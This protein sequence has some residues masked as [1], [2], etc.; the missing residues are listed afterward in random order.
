[1][2][3]WLMKT[4]P[5]EY[6]IDDLQRDTCEFWDGVRNYQARNFMRD[7]MKKGD[8]VLFYHSNTTPPGIVGLVKVVEEA[9]PDE[10]AFD[11]KDAHYDPK[12]KRENPR[13]YGVEVGFVK[14]FKEVISLDMLKNEK[15]LADMLVVQRGQRLSV[16]PVEKKHFEYIVENMVT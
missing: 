6:S 15:K 16:Q 11:P 7:D 4:E 13:W 12:S 14:K 1:M 2:R 3:Y 5:G 8:T 9:Y 10:T